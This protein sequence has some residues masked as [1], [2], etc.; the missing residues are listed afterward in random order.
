MAEDPLRDCIYQLYYNM[1]RT[2]VGIFVPAR[3]A[4]CL[5]ILKLQ[6]IFLARSSGDDIDFAYGNWGYSCGPNFCAVPPNFV[7]ILVYAKS[8]FGY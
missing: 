5:A 1:I 3:L 6:L 7:E 4:Q 2:T 8:R